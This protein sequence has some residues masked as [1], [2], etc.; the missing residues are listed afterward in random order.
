[1]KLEQR[2]ALSELVNPEEGHSLQR[3]QKV[4]WC[5]G[6]HELGMFER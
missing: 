2:L 3:L 6:E 4:E 5:S 1:M